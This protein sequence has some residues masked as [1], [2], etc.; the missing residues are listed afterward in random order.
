M[1]TISP[2]NTE[3]LND[4]TLRISVSKNE[5]TIDLFIVLYEDNHGWNYSILV[6]PFA[7]DSLN[8]CCKLPFGYNSIERNYSKKVALKKALEDIAV[9]CGIA[10]DASEYIKSIFPN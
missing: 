1:N 7:Y 4:Y 3:I 6:E 10:F 2:E 8:K 9:Y 5:E